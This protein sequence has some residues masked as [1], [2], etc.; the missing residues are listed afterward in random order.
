MQPITDDLSLDGLKN[1]VQALRETVAAL[2]AEVATLRLAAK[3]RRR[4]MG[5]RKRA[6]TLRTLRPWDKTIISH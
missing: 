2:S 3:P 5:E 1:D 6:E 4:R